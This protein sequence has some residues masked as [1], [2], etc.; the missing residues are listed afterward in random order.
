ML[1]CCVSICQ[2]SPRRDIVTAS[3]SKKANAVMK[4]KN[5]THYKGFTIVEIMVIITVIGILAGIAVFSI[6]D[7]RARTA[8]GEV[9]SDL[10]AVV[11]AMEGARTFST[12]YPA[13]IPTTFKAS[14]NVTV[15]LKSSSSSAF[16]A[17]AASKVVTSVV[18][19]VSSGNKTPAAGT[20]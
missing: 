13:S 17:E 19:K 10:N 14:P 3:I 8:K 12:G 4:I 7:W 2:P 11:S 18:Y 5:K 1:R 20:C 6:G 16:C 9:A 15:T